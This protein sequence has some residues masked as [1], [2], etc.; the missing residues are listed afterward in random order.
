MPNE[1]V[2]LVID[3]NKFSNLNE[4][5]D[6]IERVFTKN[7]S[8]KIGRNLDAFNDILRGG[9]GVHAFQQPIEIT[10]NESEKSKLAFGKNKTIKQLEK[11]LKDC[12]PND[13]K[14]I[15]QEIKDI[16]AGQAP[17]LFEKMIEIISSHDHITLKLR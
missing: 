14:Y 1:K 17:T 3:G 2:K 16:K 13:A 9:F 6:E 11:A 8:W 12:S 7:L 5:Y 4:F 10:W 15:R